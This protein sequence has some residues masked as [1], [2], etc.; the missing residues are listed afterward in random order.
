MVVNPIIR[1]ASAKADFLFDRQ[2]DSYQI[3]GKEEPTKIVDSLI[4]GAGLYKL[5]LEIV[6]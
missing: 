4:Y 2:R 6:W 5:E 1:K 3:I